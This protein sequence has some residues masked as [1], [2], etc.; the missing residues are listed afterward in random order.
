MESLAHGKILK[1]E[2]C[3]TGI[4]ILKVCMVEII[5]T[6]VDQM[7]LKNG[8]RGE[9]YEDQNLQVLRDE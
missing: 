5:G 7:G 8:G 2:R 4:Q 6:L 1:Q 9:G 3:G